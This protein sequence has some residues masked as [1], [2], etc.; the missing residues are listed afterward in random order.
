MAEVQVSLSKALKLKNRLA[1]RV[2]SASNNVA[3]FN[4]VPKDQVGQVDVNAA[5]E[6]R[7]QITGALIKLKTILSEGAS[8]IRER[9][10]TLQEMKSE[11]SWVRG[12][13]TTQ[14]IQHHG[15]RGLGETD[16]EY[17]A[18]F[19]KTDIDQVIRTLE[20]SIDN[21]QDEIDDFNASTKVS[22]PQE[23]L[24]LASS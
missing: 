6:L 1:G 9:L 23:I 3:S 5:W 11:L 21:L 12:I 13:G 22:L 20:I 16:V 19:S 7:K 8:P 18:Q 2:N 17:V 14:G 4:S 15:F 10:Y 24:D